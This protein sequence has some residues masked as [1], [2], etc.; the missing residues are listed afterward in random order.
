MTPATLLEELLRYR[1]ARPER[2]A[3]L[4]TVIQQLLDY[5]LTNIQGRV[6]TGECF[7]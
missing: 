5:C 7:P 1:Q 2:T 4:V 6:P 3:L